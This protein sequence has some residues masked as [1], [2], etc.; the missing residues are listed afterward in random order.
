LHYSSSNRNHNAKYY[1]FSAKILIPLLTKRF[2]KHPLVKLAI[3]SVEHFIE[4]GNLLPCPNPLPDKLK[5]NAGNFITMKS[6]DSLRGCVGSLTPK[7][8]NL[9][10]EIIRNSIRDANDD[11]RF[12][13]V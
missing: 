11:P 10:E 2:F 8:K 4:T 9:T 7:Y 3:K 5:Q 6:Q 13:P 12:D 1:Y